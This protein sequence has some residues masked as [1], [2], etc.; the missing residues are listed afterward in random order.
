MTHPPES[1]DL[2]R[3]LIE[4]IR[5]GTAAEKSAAEERLFK[6]WYRQFYKFFMNRGFGEA[7]C[8][9]LTQESL[10]RVFK[11][12][13]DFRGDRFGGWA[14][15]IAANIAKNEVRRKHTIKREARETS[16]EQLQTDD[17]SLLADRPSLGGSP[18]E[19]ALDRIVAREDQEKLHRAIEKMP[20]KM[21][22]CCLMRYVFG[23]KYREIAV[24]LKI[25]IGTVKAHLAQAKERLR[26]EFGIDLAPEPGD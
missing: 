16:L 24:A 9:D 11:G 3:I 4:K 8:D 14:F 12:I 6:R 15:T 19:N 26:N 21:R 7:D 23:M 2:D 22:S 18:G 17:P 10:L 13:D 1:D 5:K 20:P 25:S